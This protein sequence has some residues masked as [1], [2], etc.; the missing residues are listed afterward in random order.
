MIQVHTIIKITKKMKIHFH[1]LEILLRMKVVHNLMKIL[2]ILIHYH[3]F[4]NII[5]KPLIEV[6][7]I[8]K[9]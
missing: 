5:K 8:L 9:T 2:T 7:S 6:L 1:N 4:N 3:K